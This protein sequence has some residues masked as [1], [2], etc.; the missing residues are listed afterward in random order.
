[1]RRQWRLS[2]QHVGS[3]SSLPQGLAFASRSSCS[4]KLRS[5]W[6]P[7]AGMT[8]MVFA[9][10]GTKVLQ[11]QEP[12]HVIHTFWTMAAALEFDYHYFFCDVVEN[13][14]A[15]AVDVHV[16][17]WEACRRRLLR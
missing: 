6:E 8:N 4:S 7:F 14:G 5:S 1:M 17:I 16:P 2:C 3:K 15:A 9:G 13:P 10:P 11:L 12:R